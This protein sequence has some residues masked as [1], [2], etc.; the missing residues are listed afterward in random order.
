MRNIKK[1]DKIAILSPATVVKP[2]WIDGAA[3]ELKRRGYE[4]VLMPHA[5]GPACG[6]F[7]ASDANRL[8]DL[9]SAIKDPEIAA[10]LCARGGYGCIHLL[11]GEL[12]RLV[13]ENPKWIIGFSDISALH[14]LWQKAGV[15]SLHCSMAKQLTLYDI[16]NMPATIREAA[17]AE[18]P[19]TAQLA[20]IRECTDNMFDILEGKDCKI[21]YTA[22]TADGAIC[23]EASGKIIGGNLAVLNGLAATPWDILSAEYVSG[24]ILFLEDVGEKIYQVERMLTRLH[25]AG[26]FD[27]AAGIIFG[28]FT[29]YRPDLNFPSMEAMISA[30][31]KE[32]DVKIP[33]ALNF[34]IGHVSDN[35]P[36]PE[37]ADARML[38]T[39][40][41]TILILDR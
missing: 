39:P 31:L 21:E 27:S 38:V 4:P 40:Q 6:T 34:P 8:S 13:A 35:R 14:A 41:E 26:V 32:W 33:V 3:I 5:K 20:A 15:A 12:Q 22:P 17:A 1:G 10:I 30:R 24:K 2:F 19:G 29:D 23:G 37:G 36:I 9:V 7:A 18:T 11:S 28:Q 16:I 25:L